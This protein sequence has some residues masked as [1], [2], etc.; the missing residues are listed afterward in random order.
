MKRKTRTQQAADARYDLYYESH[1][2]NPTLLSMYEREAASLMIPEAPPDIRQ[3]EVMHIPEDEQ[4]DPYGIINT[5]SNP[6]TPSVDASMERTKLLQRA[7]SL[8]TGIDTA[9]S[10]QAKNSLEKMLAHQMAACHVKAMNLIAE[11]GNYARD[12]E[13]RTFQ[14]KQIAVAAK[15][16]EVYQK[17]METLCRTR[18]AGKQ[19][20]IVKQVHVT[21]GQ[22]VI[23]DSISAGGVT[24]GGE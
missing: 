4:H 1:R 15:L 7:S 24:G 18:N 19:T 2:P 22:N 21:G 10:I 11:G 13:T 8:E 12:L 23:A 20:I 3:G 16:M 14:L 6:D 17:G 5:L 9:N